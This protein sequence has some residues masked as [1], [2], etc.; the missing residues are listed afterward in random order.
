MRRIGTPDRNA[1]SV[2]ED[3]IDLTRRRAAHPVAVPCG[4]HNVTVDLAATALIVI[5]MQ[6]AFCHP[7]KAG[8]DG[9]ARRPIAPLQALM[10]ELR[11]RDVPVVWVN[12]GNRADGRNLAPMVLHPFR[13]GLDGES[14]IVKDSFDAAIV[15]DLE[16]GNGDVMVDKYRMSGFWDTQLDSILRNLDART[17]LFAGV[18][19]DQCVFTTLTD[20]SFLGYDC[21]LLEDCAATSSPEFCVEAALWNIGR[22]F[23]FI[24]SSRAILAALA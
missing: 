23:G 5:D 9:P 4:E 18:N 10:P 6:N 21:I 22:C 13:D 15:D 7:D 24:T 3:T 11:A 8:A 16:V 17:L 1:W 14:F 20:A 12:W 19:L 2:T